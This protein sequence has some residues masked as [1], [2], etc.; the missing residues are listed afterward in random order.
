M[1]ID[2]FHASPFL[3]AVPIDNATA[4]DRLEPIAYVVDLDGLDD[5]SCD[6]TCESK[7]NCSCQCLTGNT[8]RTD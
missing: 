2:F 1:E 6:A 5:V 8:P 3:S 7:H 4:G